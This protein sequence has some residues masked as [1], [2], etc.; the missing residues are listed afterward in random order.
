MKILATNNERTTMI[1]RLLRVFLLAAAVRAQSDMEM[2]NSRCLLAGRDCASCTSS[3]CLWCF[4][5]S[6]NTA[7]CY[8]RA[9]GCGRTGVAYIEPQSCL[10][11]DNLPTPRP[12]PSPPPLRPGECRLANGVRGQCALKSECVEPLGDKC[13]GGGCVSARPLYFSQCSERQQRARQRLLLALVASAQRRDDR[14][15]QQAAWRGS[16]QEH[17]SA[18]DDCAA[19]CAGAA[20]VRARARLRRLSQRR[21]PVVRAGT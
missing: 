18:G 10:P 21:L 14:C 2:E 11:S 15:A 8:A 12:T 19:Q 17:E 1:D 13:A 7:V 20:R 4:D 5:L 3:R 6:I 9:M 16:D